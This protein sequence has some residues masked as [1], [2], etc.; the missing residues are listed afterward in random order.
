MGTKNT[1]STK[2][3]KA[4]KATKAA[5]RAAEKADYKA[6]HGEALKPLS[7]RGACVQGRD[8]TLK[9]VR[10]YCMD[11]E[12][13]AEMR[14][15]GRQ[16]GGFQN[17][18]R[19]TGIYGAA[20]QALIDL[21]I[22]EA[23]SFKAVRNRVMQIMRKVPKGDSNAWDVFVNR[24]PRNAET[25]KDPNGRLIQTYQVLQ[26]ITGVNPYGEKLRQLFA[27]VDILQGPNDTMLFRLNTKFRNY[28]SVKPTN[29]CK[30][31]G[32]KPKATKAKATKAK[33]PKKAAK[34]K[35]KAPKKAA[36]KKTAKKAK[37]RKR[38]AKKSPEQQTPAPVSAPV[39]TP[40][41]TPAAAAAK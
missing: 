31:R 12:K 39:E 8:G 29:E 35:A 32:R 15:A 5:L 6:L 7:E 2:A 25:G 38:P 9:A 16:D 40:D 10:R 11:G 18:H 14:K 41:G 13:A 30:R 3:T 36:A 33:A 22:N 37:A 34:P 4:K 20:V 19:L 17:P 26:R 23:H 28:D 24:A 1:K 27:C 21:G